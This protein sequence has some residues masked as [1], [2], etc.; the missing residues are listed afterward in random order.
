MQIPETRFESIIIHETAEG[1]CYAD[2]PNRVLPWGR[3]MEAI[4][5]AQNFHHPGTLFSL[6]S[7]RYLKTRTSVQTAPVIKKFI[8]KDF[9]KF[10]TT[11][12]FEMICVHKFMSVPLILQMELVPKNQLLSEMP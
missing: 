2:K 1:R 10:V 5:S 3:W 7:T 12:R 8:L 4:T 9:S 6:C 11:E